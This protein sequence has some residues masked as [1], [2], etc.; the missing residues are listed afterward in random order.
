MKIISYENQDTKLKNLIVVCKETN[1][2]KKLAVV[3]FVL[4]SNQLNEIGIK[5]GTRKRSGEMLVEYMER[6]NHIFQQNLGI[7][8]FKDYFITT[9]L[10]LFVDRFNCFLV[11]FIIPIDY[12]VF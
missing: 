7:L 3:G 2:F 10:N 6:I 9:C 8:I 4:I 12:T 1:N 11:V 5:L